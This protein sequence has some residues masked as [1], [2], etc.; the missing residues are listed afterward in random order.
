MTTPTVAQVVADLDRLG[1]LVSFPWHPQ[2]QYALAISTDVGVVIG[3]TQSG[4]TAVG[5]G[6]VSRLARRE[7]PIYRRLRNPDTRPLKIWVAPQTLEKF[8]SNWERRLL[9]E[10]F[11]G[12]EVEYTQ[13]P[14]PVFRWHDGV[15]RRLAEGKSPEIAA[16][17]RDELWCKSHDQGPFAFESDVVDLVL[18]D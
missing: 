15:T 16:G 1:P 6:I 18:F 2:Q 8:K 9:S 12:M 13:S 11:Q 5:G 7:G 3:G 4:K 14:F 17:L 10:A